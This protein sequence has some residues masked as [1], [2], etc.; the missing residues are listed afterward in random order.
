MEFSSFSEV[1]RA[2]YSIEFISLEYGL[3][4][5]IFIPLLWFIDM[6]A[7]NN[8]SEHFNSTLDFIRNTSKKLCK[9]KHIFHRLRYDDLHGCYT[10]VDSFLTPS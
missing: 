4:H 8:S 5:A 10:P 3:L 1:N 7:L 2:P 9:Y 6:F